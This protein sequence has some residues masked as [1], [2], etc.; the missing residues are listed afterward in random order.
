VE[1]TKP[2]AKEL[3]RL[4]GR[5]LTEGDNKRSPATPLPCTG[6]IPAREWQGTTRTVAGVSAKNNTLVTSCSWPFRRFT[7]SFKFESFTLCTC[8]LTERAMFQEASI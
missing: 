7:G 6:I 1:L 5:V 8:D 4:L 2:V 3:D